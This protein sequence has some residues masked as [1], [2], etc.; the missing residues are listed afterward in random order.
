MEAYQAVISYCLDVLKLRK[1]SPSVIKDNVAAVKLY[2]SLCFQVEGI[3][4]MHGKYGSKY[5]DAIRMALF[6]LKEPI[7][8]SYLVNK[9]L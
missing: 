7:V 3:Y 6:N 8:Q 4:R 9:S 5:C 2:K 1:T